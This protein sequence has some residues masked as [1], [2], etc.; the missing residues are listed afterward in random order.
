M[1]SEENDAEM[2]SLLK[3]DLVRLKGDDENYGEI[4]E[5]Q[6]EIVEYIIPKT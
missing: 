4:E 3:D 6:E 1:I 2:V 5:L